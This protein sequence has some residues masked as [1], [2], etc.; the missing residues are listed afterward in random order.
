MNTKTLKLSIILAVSTLVIPNSLFA[1]VNFGT[2]SDLANT[3]ADTVVTSL[4]YLM[5]TLAVVAFFWG[6]VQFIWAARQG[7]AG[8]GV[9]NGKQFMLWGLISLFVMFSVWGIIQF[10]QKVLDIK[11][12]T[13]IVIPRIRILGSTPTTSTQRGAI[14]P[15]GQTKNSDGQ[16]VTYAGSTGNP[17]FDACMAAGGGV[18]DCRVQ[19]CPYS[20]QAR[21]GAGTCVNIGSGCT[22]PLGAGQSAGTYDESGQCIA[23]SGDGRTKVGLGGSC[24][25]SGECSSGLVCDINGVDISGVCLIPK[26]GDCSVDRDCADEGLCD[27]SSKKCR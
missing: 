18:G 20:N 25:I 21:T 10:A 3:L 14:C 22:V 16:C 24:H 15:S 8:K 9:A 26:G 6:I 12:E 17:A 23:N 13:S 1:A 2:L 5:F 4:G 19:T 7:D 27:A 11:G